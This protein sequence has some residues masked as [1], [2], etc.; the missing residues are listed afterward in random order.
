MTPA[1]ARVAPRARPTLGPPKDIPVSNPSIQHARVAVVADALRTAG[2]AEAMPATETG[3][4]AMTAGSTRAAVLV[5]ILPQQT[6]RHA[7]ITLI[8]AT[9][10]RHRSCGWRAHLG[11]NVPAPVIAAAAN[12]ALSAPMPCQTTP[13]TT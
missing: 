8:S 4:V 11:A 13:S 10:R 1:G 6:A 5:R 12:A 3:V 2:F 7:F 9:C